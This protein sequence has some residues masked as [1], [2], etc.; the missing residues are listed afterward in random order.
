MSDTVTPARSR[1]PWV[2]LAVAAPLLAVALYYTDVN[3]S[4]GSDPAW[5]GAGTR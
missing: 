4:F 2:I 3:G 5:E 1:I